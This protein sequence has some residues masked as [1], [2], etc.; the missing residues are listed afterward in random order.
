MAPEPI[1][2]GDESA[3]KS[4]KEEDT[5][6]KNGEDGKDGK[7]G[8]TATLFAAALGAQGGDAGSTPVTPMPGGG[9]KGGNGTKAEPSTPVSPL[10]PKEI[11]M[12]PS[13]P[14]R[15]VY[16][17]PS[18]P[19]PPGLSKPTAEGGGRGSF[20]KKF[21]KPSDGAGGGGAGGGG[22][23]GGG[24]G[25]GAGGLLA[26]AAA[27]RAKK[28]KEES[29]ASAG[30]LSVSLKTLTSK[31]Q[32]KS[33]FASAPDI[34]SS[35]NPQFLSKSKEKKALGFGGAMGMGT[36][37]Q[38]AMKRELGDPSRSME[39]LSSKGMGI[40]ERVEEDGDDAAPSLVGS[41]GGKRTTVMKVSFHA[42][43]SKCSSL[44]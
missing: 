15:M 7:K 23:G 9:S 40:Q 41:M 17:D 28:E 22:G 4:A 39:N 13:S 36:L 29:A 1:A 5:A 26:L 32:Q 37:A 11:D 35:D 24:G 27:N 12:N 30:V 8:A 14:G 16:M 25:M 43:S 38:H 31:E 42:P 21:V 2:E 19:V 34:T 20:R 18:S 44:D 33:L 6:G 10:P 3:S